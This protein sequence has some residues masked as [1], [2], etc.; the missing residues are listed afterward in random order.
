MEVQC[1]WLAI[2]D[3]WLCIFFVTASD[4]NLQLSDIVVSGVGLNSSDPGSNPA[5]DF[6]LVIKP[7]C[8]FFNFIHQVGWC[9]REV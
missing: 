4:K 1:Y 5:F 3:A 9:N 6:R 2:K 7:A 8:F